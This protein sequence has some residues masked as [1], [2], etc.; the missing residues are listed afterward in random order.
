MNI[1]QKIAVAVM[2]LA[3]IADLF[4]AM[5]LAHQAPAEFNATFCKVFFGLLLPI[6]AA[7]ITTIRCLRAKPGATADPA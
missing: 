3:I 5:Y 7:G 1:T 2:D 4:V 6:L